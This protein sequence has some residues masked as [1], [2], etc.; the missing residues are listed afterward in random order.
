MMDRIS[1][2]EALAKR[3]EIDPFLTQMLTG[4]EKWVTYDNIVQK[5]SWSKRDEVAQ[6][7]FKQELTTREVLLFIWWD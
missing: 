3:N 2:C 5:Q 7:V 4:D 1:I 6:T